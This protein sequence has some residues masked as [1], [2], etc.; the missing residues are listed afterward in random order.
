MTAHE[1]SLWG[2]ALAVGK[3]P[4]SHE[5][6]GPMMALGEGPCT[7]FTEAFHFSISAP[8]DAPAGPRKAL[9]LLC[10]TA[11]SAHSRVIS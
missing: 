8:S 3:L 4:S 2:E 11:G 6:Y 1:A 10:S 7:G 5:T 9:R